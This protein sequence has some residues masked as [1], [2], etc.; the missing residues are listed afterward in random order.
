MTRCTWSILLGVSPF[1]LLPLPLRAQEVTTPVVIHGRVENAVSRDPVEGVRVSSADSSSVVYTDSL[2]TFA[3]PLPADGSFVVE[4]ERL[5]YLSQRF[6]LVEDAASR[7]LVLLLEPAPI[8]IQGITVEVRSA[9]T[10][11]VKNLE[12]RRNAYP[13][14][15]AAFDRAD[16]DRA[17]AATFVGEFLHHAVPRL[18]PCSS[19]PFQMCAPGRYDPE[20]SVMIC[21]DGRK[22]FYQELEALPTDLVALVEIYGGRLRPKRVS[23]YTRQWILSSARNGR[24]NVTP[25]IMGC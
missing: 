21:L 25:Y 3:I 8:A 23:V 13:R 20:T 24:T 1:L 5:G 7:L 12:R 18:E 10:K 22:A 6:E 14:A 16:L 15:M 19:D 2:G 11:L 17:L 4:A 9:L